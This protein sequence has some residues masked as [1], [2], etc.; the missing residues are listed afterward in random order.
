MRLYSLRGLHSIGKIKFK[1]IK[2]RG[3]KTFGLVAAGDMDTIVVSAAMIYKLLKQLHCDAGCFPNSLTQSVP[4]NRY[5]A[6][7]GVPFR[8]LVGTIWSGPLWSCPKI[9]IDLIFRLLVSC[10]TSSALVV[11]TSA[12]ILVELEVPSPNPRSSISSRLLLFKIED[13]LVFEKFFLN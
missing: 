13:K 11:V 9:R 4:R 5:L 3:V 10:A 2:Y 8:R 1:K 6:E 7:S 12:S